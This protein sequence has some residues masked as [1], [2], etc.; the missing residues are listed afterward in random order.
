MVFLSTTPAILEAINFLR[1]S[2]TADSGL[3]DNDLLSGFADFVL[4]DPITHTQVIL[5][6]KLLKNLF[7]PEDDF[8]ASY[9]L[10]HLLQG[11]RVYSTPPK[12][13]KETT[14]EYK[15]LMARLKREEEARAYERMTNPPLPMET[16]QQR[17]PNT[18]NTKLF[19]GNQAQFEQD[20]DVTYADVN[21]QMAMIINILV[22]IV[23][24]SIALWL[25]ASRWSTP[26]RLALSMGGSI[27]VAVAEAV[28]YAGYLRRVKEARENGKKQVEIKEIIKT[29]VIGGDEKSS[30]QEEPAEIASIAPTPADV[31]LPTILDATARTVPA[32]DPK[33]RRP[34]ETQKTFA[35]RLR[36]PTEFRMPPMANILSS[37]CIGLTAA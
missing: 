10:E 30:Q 25:V 32:F 17:F 14:S 13:K 36:S 20:D 6:S 28:V 11:S 21:R 3:N 31:H 22:S 9:R 37:Q 12:P 2:E 26:P 18:S 33:P 29:W 1:R 34:C 16:F 5:I 15:A 8:P 24:C 4:G 23:A 7:R 19:A 35:T 27:V